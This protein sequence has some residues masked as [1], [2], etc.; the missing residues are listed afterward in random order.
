MSNESD[1]RLLGLKIAVVEDDATIRRLLEI[2]LSA[3]G[4]ASVVSTGDGALALELLRRE[5]PDVTLLD[6]MLPGLDGTSICRKI[7]ADP[8]LSS[9]GVIMLTAKGEPEDIVAGLDA[10]ADDYVTKPFSRSVLLA[11]ISAVRRRIETSAGEEFDGLLVD[12]SSH[13][14]KLD[15][16]T[17]SLTRTEWIILSKFTA[18]PGRVYTRKQLADAVGGGDGERTVD[19]QIA[20]LRKKLGRWASHVET[21][22]GVGYRVI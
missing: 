21:I 5:L 7:R 22:R 10:G 4:A 2:T 19:V 14:A 18:R 20:G 13:H 9:S 16:R 12:G 1:S 15:G 17:L 11:R 3:S 6:I 8:G